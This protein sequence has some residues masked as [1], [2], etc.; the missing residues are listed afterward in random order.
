[1]TRKISL[2]FLSGAI[3]FG[4]FS[5]ISAN[6]CVKACQKFISCTEEV[7]KRKA[8]PNEKALLEKGCSVTCKN[9]TDKV[10]ECYNASKKES[11]NSCGVYQKCIMK[12]AGKKKK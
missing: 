1:M 12:Y 4:G 7:N 3:F 11:W 5:G 10:I 8:L 9:N 6:D 2:L